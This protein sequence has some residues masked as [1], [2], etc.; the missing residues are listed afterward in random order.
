[1]PYTASSSQ[2]GP[3]R[4]RMAAASRTLAG[5]GHWPGI[6][7]PGAGVGS[8]V[9]LRSMRQPAMWILISLHPNKE[10]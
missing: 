7:A 8:A 4:K 3:A 6:G 9:A 2:R 1:D 10:I 5:A